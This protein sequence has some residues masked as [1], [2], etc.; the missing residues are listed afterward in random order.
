MEYRWTNEEIEHVL[1]Q[2]E[3]M[4]LPF[5][6]YKFSKSDNGLEVI[7]KGGF[8]LVYKATSRLGNDKF[9]I[10]VVGFGDKTVDFREMHKVLKKQED[11]SSVHDNIVK[12][13]AYKQVDIKLDDN[14]KIIDVKCIGEE[15]VDELGTEY[16][17]LMFIVME[18]IT[19]VLKFDQNG[20]AIIY[21]SKLADA[22]KKEVCK[23][24]YD[25][26]K[27]LQVLHKRNILHRDVKLENI[28]YDEKTKNYKL[29]DFGISKITSMGTA[30][31]IAF[32]K[33]YGA[34][35]IVGAMDAKYDTTVD[36]YSL[37]IVMYLLFNDLSFPDSSRYIANLKEQY[38]SDYVVPKPQKASDEVYEIIVKM[39]KYDPK[40]RYQ[41]IDL[42]L[43]DIEDVI[44]Q[45]GV[46]YMSNHIGGQYV[47]GAVLLFLGVVLTN[48]I[49]DG[50][51]NIEM[52]I[53]M[54]IFM[55]LMLVLSI[56]GILG[57][58]DIH[59]RAIMLITG[60]VLCVVNQ[61]SILN[62]IVLFVLTYSSWQF[63]LLV[64]GGVMV[65]YLT[66]LFL[67]AELISGYM[68]DEYK[69]LMLLT[70]TLAIFTLIECMVLKDRNIESAK[71]YFKKNTY[72]K[73]VVA[74]Y[75]CMILSGLMGDFEEFNLVLV[76]MI[77]FI[78]NCVWV[79][80]QDIMCKVE[81][82]NS[83]K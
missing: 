77:G 72:R 55:S 47:I 73:Y 48:I 40:E 53:G 61:S 22:K 7:G 31:T 24:V 16:L 80:R 62:W 41:T 57:K 59:I 46:G 71:L 78:I 37:G 39:T 18:R 36:I 26:G 14:N 19:P 3:T 76:G 60:I 5:Y 6:N 68:M 69:W 10:K 63:L 49:Y 54:V 8:G 30:K 70:V 82:K 29:A 56:L 58:E 27:A 66:D 79:I 81:L 38:S 34:P 83:R 51:I 75:L 17:R 74:I 50:L 45:K 15:D 1:L 25:I 23:L 33:G 42:V 13:Y 32:T 52:S 65:T 9:A 43:N 20:N 67:E 2:L 11:I 35:E 4:N 21:P 12:I 64:L 44:V 28:F